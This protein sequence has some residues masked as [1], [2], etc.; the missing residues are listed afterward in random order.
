MLDRA[1]QLL[2]R[3]L[4]NVRDG[5]VIPEVTEALVALYLA[6]GEEPETVR[7]AAADYRAEHERPDDRGC[8]CPPGLIARG[9]W[10]STCPIHGRAS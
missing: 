9:G 5:D 7:L 8:S 10:R 1:E 4:G 3:A 6:D 2:T